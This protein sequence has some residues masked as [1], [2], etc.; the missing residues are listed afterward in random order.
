MFTMAMVLYM[1]EAQKRPGL[2]E[3]E[4]W[5]KIESSYPKLASTVLKDCD[6]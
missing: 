1:Q 5:K 2:F 3:T 6:G 4:E